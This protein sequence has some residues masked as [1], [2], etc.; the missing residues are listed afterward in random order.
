MTLSSRAR[1]LGSEST[2]FSLVYCVSRA[3]DKAKELIRKDRSVGILI[4]SRV[5]NLP[6]SVIGKAIK[7]IP[8][9]LAWS[10]EASDTDCPPEEKE[11]YR[12]RYIVIPA[13]IQ[14]AQGESHPFFETPELQ[15]FYARSKAKILFGKPGGTPAK[16]KSCLLVSALG[17]LQ[18][19]LGHGNF[20]SKIRR[21]SP[22]PGPRHYRLYHC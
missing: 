17:K 6:V 4:L 9:D 3:S 21:S 14:M 22:R 10:L 13:F 2:A 20:V 16:P 15:P 7:E 12:Y 8:I 18:C 11:L 5:S 1:I 19:L